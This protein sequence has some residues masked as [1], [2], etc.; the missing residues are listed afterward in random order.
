MNSSFGTK[1][2]HYQFFPE[3]LNWRWVPVYSLPLLGAKIDG[4]TADI[5]RVLWHQR[6]RLWVLGYRVPLPS[7]NN[8]KPFVV[9]IQSIK[10][11]QNHLIPRSTLKRIISFL[12]TGSFSL[13][14][15]FPSIFP[16]LLHNIEIKDVSM[17]LCGRRGRARWANG[18]H[19][20]FFYQRSVSNHEPRESL[21][22]RTLITCFCKQWLL[23]WQTSFL[24]L[25]EI[26]LN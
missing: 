7:L 11:L 16:L 20:D 26:R 12:M 23:S 10:L 25:L 14:A 9:I 8:K 2:W 3:L 5:H 6:R 13:S 21:E 15:L 4:V 1:A 17:V 22:K 19:R 18:S 24:C